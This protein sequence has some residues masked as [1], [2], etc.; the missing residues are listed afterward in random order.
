MKIVIDDTICKN[1][2]LDIKE[3]SIL[4]AHNFGLVWDKTYN[5]LENKGFLHKGIL[6]DY[7]TTQKGKDLLNQIILD[8]IATKPTDKER[9]EA[10]AIKLKEVYPK[11]RKEGTNYMWRGTTAEIVRKLQTL[12]VKY[13]F[14]FTDEEAVDATRSYVESF[15]GDYRFMQLLKYFLFKTVRDADGNT[16]IKSEFMSRIE[17]KG[18]EEEMRQDW[19]STLI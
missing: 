8:S 10:L 13:D 18:Q 9:L 11:G 2:N 5:D 4:L 12:I 15:N 19:L 14:N 17:N 3:V 7:Q 1:N 16:E 6:G